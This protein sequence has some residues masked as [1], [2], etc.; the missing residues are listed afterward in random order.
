MTFPKELKL[1]DISSLH[2]KDDKFTKKNYRPIATLPSALKIYER[3]TESQITPFAHGF[4]SPL[5]C[6]FRRNYSTQH[7]L[8]RFNENCKIALDTKQTASALL[9]DLSKHLT[10]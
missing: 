7:T 2:K 6:G 8:L 9:M 10:V 3:L 1:G 5:L 4:L